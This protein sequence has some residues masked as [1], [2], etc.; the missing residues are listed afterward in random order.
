MIIQILFITI[1]IICTLLT[2]K[3]KKWWIMAICA[4]VLGLWAFVGI[5]SV[6]V[7]I[8]YISLLA[9]QHSLWILAIAFLLSFCAVFNGKSNWHD[10]CILPSG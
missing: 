3:S 6:I 5:D 4:V 2:F 1:V 9:F 8:D 7:F 10:S